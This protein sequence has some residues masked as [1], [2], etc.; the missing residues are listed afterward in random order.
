MASCPRPVAERAGRGR[1]DGT[2]RTIPPHA[3]CQV[4]VFTGLQMRSPSGGRTRRQGWPRAFG[5]ESRE[6][7]RAA[8]RG[9][10][11]PVESTRLLCRRRRERECPRLDS[12]LG[13]RMAPD[14]TDT[15]LRP[16][17]RSAPN[18]FLPDPETSGRTQIWRRSP[19]ALFRACR[20]GIPLAAPRLTSSSRSS[21][22][23]A[24]WRSWYPGHSRGAQRG[25]STDRNPS[26]L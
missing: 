2:N 8:V 20:A 4:L 9:S 18:S 14:T 11:S 5:R 21:P 12:S 15:T 22:T 26:P 7:N 19:R 10:F 3:S 1:A 25:S 6:S 23:A 16:L 24:A 13:R 17:T